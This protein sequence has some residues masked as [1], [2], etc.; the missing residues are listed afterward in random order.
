MAYPVLS[1]PSLFV[2]VVTLNYCIMVRSG[3]SGEALFR[4]VASSAVCGLV[5]VKGGWGVFL[6]QGRDGGQQ[7]LNQTKH[8][9]SSLDVKEQAVSCSATPERNMIFK[10]TGKP[11]ECELIPL[12]QM[13]PR[14][15]CR[16]G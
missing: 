16:P 2:R 9:N 13:Q 8:L 15:L 14:G 3:T 6:V 4:L 5:W 1:D 7:L 10:K 12:V 11:S